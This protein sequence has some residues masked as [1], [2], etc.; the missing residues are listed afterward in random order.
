MAACLP[1]R[2]A[3]MPAGR[4]EFCGNLAGCDVFDME[5]LDCGIGTG[6][7]CVAR[8]LFTLTWFRRVRVTQ[9]S[10]ETAANLQQETITNM[11]SRRIG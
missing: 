2:P 8:W 3:S 11:Q 7:P 9:R 5:L 1:V 6:S 10:L 4:A